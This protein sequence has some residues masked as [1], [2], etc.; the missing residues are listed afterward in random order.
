[1]LDAG[2]LS[3]YSEGLGGRLKLSLRLKALPKTFILSGYQSD[4][5]ISPQERI[6]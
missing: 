2:R 3:G 6:G 5:F 4:C 1:M